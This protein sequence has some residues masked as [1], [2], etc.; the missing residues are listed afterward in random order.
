MFFT[1]LLFVGS[2]TF[3]QNITNHLVEPKGVYKEIN[4]S[5]DIRVIQ[6]LGDTVSNSSLID[7]VERN[8]NNYTPPVL[9]VLS[10]ILFSQKKYNDACYWFYIAQLRA[11]Y[12]VNRCTDKT[13][14]PFVYTQTF[15][16]IINEYAFKHLDNLKIIIQKVVDF[17]RTNEEK[18]DQRWINLTGM[19]AMTASLSDKAV[20]KKLSLDKSQWPAIKKKTIDDYYND[21][22]EA[23]DRDITT[24]KS[25]LP[26][27]D[28]RL[29]QGSPAWELT[30]AVADTDINKIKELVK[31]DTSLLSY[32]EPRFGQSLLKLAVMN[33]NYLSVKTL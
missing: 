6:L 20:N 8:A 18:Y 13:A 19:E 4:L 26:S 7:S 16:P 27:R 17:V 29:F 24:D 23:T 11:R 1:F 12:D 33:K 14:T 28:Y 31:K 3:A 5:N 30:K 2:I 21:F 15:G 9:Y 32:R 22:K 10:N 25:T